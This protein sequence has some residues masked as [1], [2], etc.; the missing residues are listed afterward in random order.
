MVRGFVVGLLVSVVCLSASLC[1]AAELQA[2]L[3]EV[4][5]TVEVCP[6]G[7]AAFVPAVDGMLINVGDTVRTGPDGSATI[8]FLQRTVLQLR[9]NTS[10]KVEKHMIDDATQAVN[11]SSEVLSGGVRAIVNDLPPAST[12]EVKTGTAVAA[13]RGTVYYVDKDGNIYVQ[14]GSITV[15]N[16]ITGETVTVYAGEIVTIAE[17]G[18]IGQPQP[19]S[20]EQIDQITSNYAPITA[21]PYGP[22]VEVAPGIVVTPNTDD[23]FTEPA[24][25][26]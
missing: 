2:T 21:E 3:A 5:G 12:F 14:D 8:V 7:A 25:E 22:P 13:S 6:V 16:I 4:K 19:A 26:F 17:D 24:S 9:A 1:C 10:V 11:S 15:T 23:P 18:T 20:Q